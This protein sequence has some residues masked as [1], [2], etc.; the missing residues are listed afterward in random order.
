LN[1]LTGITVFEWL[2]PY[3]A[4]VYAIA[5][6]VGL[7]MFN[8]RIKQASLNQYHGLGAIITGMICGLIGARL[9]HVIIYYDRYPNI[10]NALF[11]VAGSTISWG[12]YLG[13]TIGF[14]TYLKIKKC[15]ILPYLDVVGS[16]L[17]LGVFIGRWSC[18]LN[19]CDF[20]TVTS[21]PWGVSFPHGSI[22]FF[23][24]LQS[25][26]ISRTALESLPVHPLQ[27]YLSTN[28]LII[29]LIISKLWRLNKFKP[30]II[31]FTYLMAYSITRFFIEFLRG[32]TQT[33]YFE[34]FSLGQVMTI[35]FII[36]SSAGIFLISSKSR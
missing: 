8:R 26:L 12:A 30:G 23:A 31:F 35:L 22:P 17:G 7:L 15:P 20:G 28:G 13:G 25:G 2:V 11:Q 29:F 24:Q 14:L 34:I 27:I 16:I 18:F 10:I 33:F 4:L 6:F 9:F 21:L 36:I 5:M 32:D 3:P 1:E 19:G